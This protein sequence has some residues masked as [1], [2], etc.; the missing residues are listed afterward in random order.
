MQVVGFHQARRPRL[1]AG[2]K[3]RRELSLPRPG[4]II[5]CLVG[6]ALVFNGAMALNPD[7][8][9]PVS[10]GPTPSTTAAAPS[11]TSAPPSLQAA[12]PPAQATAPASAVPAPL[13]ASGGSP[14]PLPPPPVPSTPVAVAGAAPDSALEK[15]F[16]TGRATVKDKALADLGNPE[17]PLVLVNKRNP[18]KP[19]DFVPADLVEPAIGPGTSDTVLL[20]A[21]AATAAEQMFAAAAAQNVHISV[22][23]SYR[24]YA[25]QLEVYHGYVADKGV[26]AADSTSARAGFSEHQTGLALDVGDADAGT[27]CDLSSCF[28]TTPAGL[29]VAAHAAE[30]GFVVRYQEGDQPVTGYLGEPWHLRYLGTAVAQ[31]MQA[32]GMPSYEKYAG[33]SDAPDYG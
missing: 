17:S 9:G 28:A 5:V 31:D 10:P 6:A 21:E 15:L 24:S 19:L 13:S 14:A 18:L 23:S 7:E 33:L 26:A 1:S 29:W 11:P 20:R 27:G 30:H 12:S 22:K 25:K 3:L 2:A 16:A 8:S 32:L 4:G